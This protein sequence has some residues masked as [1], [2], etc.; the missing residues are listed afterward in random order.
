MLLSGR[1]TQ[2][3]VAPSGASTL[4]ISAPS[5]TKVRSAD[6]PCELFETSRPLQLTVCCGLAGTWNSAESPLVPFSVRF[7]RLLALARPRPMLTTSTGNEQLF[8]IARAR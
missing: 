7:H 6:P 8:L 5:R 2:R 4:Y 3:L 1:N